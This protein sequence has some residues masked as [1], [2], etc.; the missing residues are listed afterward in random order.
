MHLLQHMLT[1]DSEP[2]LFKSANIYDGL[3]GE[4]RNYDLLLSEG[5]ILEIGEAIT[6]PGVYGN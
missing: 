3:G 5:K 2:V 1:M 4:F 6:A